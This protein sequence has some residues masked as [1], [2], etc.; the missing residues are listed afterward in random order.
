MAAGYA[1][2]ILTSNA[3]LIERQSLGNLHFELP[4]SAGCGYTDTQ[5]VVVCLDIDYRITASEQLRVLAF[6]VDP[7]RVHAGSDRALTVVM[8]VLESV[9]RVTGDVLTSL[10]N[11]CDGDCARRVTLETQ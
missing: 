9:P 1:R 2:P 5:H 3:R 11:N 6:A 8:K 4:V 10:A 7:V